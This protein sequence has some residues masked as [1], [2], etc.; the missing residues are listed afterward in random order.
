MFSEAVRGAAE[1]IP[2]SN[3]VL[4][5]TKSCADK[6]LPSSIYKLKAEFGKVGHMFPAEFILAQYRGDF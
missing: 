6:S 1:G 2:F 5:L 4:P 3:E